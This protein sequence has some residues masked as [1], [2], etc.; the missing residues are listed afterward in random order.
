MP[1][2]GIC[3]GFQILTEAGLLPGVLLR[4]AEPEVHLP[5]RASAGRDDADASSPSATQTG[6]VM[7]V[8]VAH[9]DGNYFADRTRSTGSRTTARWRSATA[10]PTA[11]VTPTA[12]PNGSARNIAGIFND[13]QER[14]GPDAASRER[15]RRRCSAR[16]TARRSST[17][18]SRRVA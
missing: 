17:A 8:P 11:T 14:A 7:R 2:I 13:D 15:D 6:Q 10:A 4:N 5:R 16:P 12:N 3:N 9:H 1:V 18:W